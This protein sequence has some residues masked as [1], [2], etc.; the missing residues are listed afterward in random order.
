[1]I[2]FLVES[3]FTPKNFV[4]R[5]QL[6]PEGKVLEFDVLGFSGLE[7]IRLPIDMVIPVTRHDYWGAA[8]YYPFF[9]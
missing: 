1:M 4:T 9:K 5:L 3:R 6:Y 2:P 8:G 7:T